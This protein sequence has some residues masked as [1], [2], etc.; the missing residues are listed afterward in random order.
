MCSA[1]TSM[2]FQLIDKR[3]V[4]AL[5]ACL[6]A[7]RF[8]HTG[9]LW[10]EEAYP[11]AAAR[12]MLS[13]KTLYRDIWFDKPPLFPGFYTLFNAT[14]GWPLRLAG[15]LFVGFAAWAAWRAARQ[16]WGREGDAAGWAAVLTA[17]FLTFDFP[18]TAMALTPDLLALPF[19]ILTVGALAAGQPL[20]AGVFCGVALGF[21]GKALII[22]LLCVLWRWW[23][24][25]RILAGF[26]LPVAVLAGWMGAQGC[27]LEHWQQ[28]WVWG[29]AYSRDTPYAHPLVEGLRRTLN[30]AGFHVAIVA[31]AA[32]A[33]IRERDRRWRLLGWI[34]VSLASA[35]MGWR[36]F[37]RY[38]F[39]LL[40]ALALPAARGFSLASPRWRAV[41]LALLAIPLIRFLPASIQLAAETLQGRPHA[42]R[43]LAL[44]EDSRRAAQL[45]TGAPGSARTA[46][47]WG[48]RPELY[49][50]AELTPGTRFLDSQPLSGVLADRHLIDSKQTF[51]EL[52]RQN[53]EALLATP[54]PEWILDG[55][56]PINGQISVFNAQTGLAAWSPL[57]TEVGRSA[58]VIVYA[59][60]S[61][62]EGEASGTA[63]PF[64]A[65]MKALSPAR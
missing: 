37:P 6:A 10:V 13:G 26:A 29:A 38:F 12:A 3:L 7:L 58:T 52:S 9:V 44:F 34:V 36:F 55:L 16:L 27:L 65:R 32:C 54:P 57:Y 14:M 5:V 33:L 24:T 53:R 48:Y 15:A 41:L 35:W 61:R 23:E 11:L 2:R 17:F 47:V 46:L 56:G 21:N 51:P 49:T 4:S 39:Q 59:R 64:L 30:W 18:S 45:V 25:P 43:D 20:L 19:H 63:H 62:R 28:V 8:C 42:S 22:L 60:A 40:P 31:A 1:R 50:L